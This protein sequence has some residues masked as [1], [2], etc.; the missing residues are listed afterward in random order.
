MIKKDKKEEEKRLKKEEFVS[1]NGNIKI[2]A[3]RSDNGGLYGQMEVG[4]S[5]FKAKITL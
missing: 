5:Q 3:L 4:I 1:C 2:Q